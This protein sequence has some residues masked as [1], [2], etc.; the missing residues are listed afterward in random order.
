MSRVSY[1]V[2]WQSVK[3]E[4]ED[5]YGEIVAWV[6]SSQGAVLTVS[7]QGVVFVARGLQSSTATVKRDDVDELDLEVEGKRLALRLLAK[8]I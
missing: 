2:C 1:P 6:A 4:E 5:R 7:A 8:L 3:S